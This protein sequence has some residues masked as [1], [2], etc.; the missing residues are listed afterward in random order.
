SGLE[1]RV[2]VLVDVLLG[3]HGGVEL[4]RARHLVLHEIRERLVLG[5]QTGHRDA[6]GGL[7]GGVD[8]GRLHHRV[9]LLDVA[10]HVGRTGAADQEELVTTGV[11]DR[12]QNAHALVV[13]VV[14][15]GIDLRR[16]LQ[17]VRGRGLAALDGEVPGDAVVDLLAALGQRVREALGALLRQRQGGDAGDLGDHRLGI[18]PDALAD[19]LAGV[20]AHAVVVAHDGDPGGVGVGELAVDVDHR[21]AGLHRFQCDTG[22]GRAVVGDHDDR[23]HLVV[24][25]EG[26]DLAD[27]EVDVVGALGD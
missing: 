21:D 15:D 20:V 18:V 26:L 22:Q 9:A 27:L 2:D 11:L 19:V 13:V 1:G 12:G 3:H 23:V 25:D 5:Q 8:H 7:A 10:H 14:P 17:Q 6:V 4:H 24:V 16:G